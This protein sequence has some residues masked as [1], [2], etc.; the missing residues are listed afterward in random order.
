MILIL[1]SS[2]SAE[3]IH[4]S[5][6]SNSLLENREM[7]IYLPPDYQTSTDNYPVVYFLHGMSS[8][9][10]DYSFMLNVILDGMIAAGGMDPIIAAVPDGRDDFYAGSMYTNSDLYGLCENYIAFDVIQ[11]VEANYRARGTRADRA[12]MG[13]SMGG[14]GALRI[15]FKHPDL[16]YGVVSLSGFVSIYP[17]EFWRSQVL[18]E[19]GGQAP[20]TYNINNGWFTLATVTAAGAFT[21][22]LDNPPY[23][24]DLPLDANGNVVPVV[25]EL[26]YQQMPGSLSRLD[27]NVR[28]LDI[29]FDCGTQDE[30]GFYPMTEFFHAQLDSQNI[31]HRFESFNGDHTNQLSLRGMLAFLHLDTARNQLPVES[32]AN[33]S[34]PE[35]ISLLQ[36]YPNPFN[37]ATQI[38]FSLP[39][40]G[41]TRLVVYDLLGREVATLID[42]FASAGTHAVRFDG[43]G[44]TSGVYLC[45]LETGAFARTRKIVLIK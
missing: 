31:M 24:V 22:N 44:L 37:A 1:F 17:F 6:Y 3:I 30:L 8:S 16:F 14:Y 20:Y 15:A 45:R 38:E 4:D 27:P 5:F 41:N 36:N 33:V 18:A 29:Y 19:N 2:A 21:P 28:N 35:R 39:V 32:P 12:I 13:H 43:T 34:V 26:W 9:P 25:Q 10:A 40:A 23:M 42:G 7:D 11:Y